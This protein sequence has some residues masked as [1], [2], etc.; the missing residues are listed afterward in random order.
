MEDCRVNYDGMKTRT[1]SK[2][3]CERQIYTE[4]TKTLS[5]EHTLLM[6]HVEG[7]LWYL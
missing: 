4:S 2:V 3:L 1:H 5:N 7:L 6:S